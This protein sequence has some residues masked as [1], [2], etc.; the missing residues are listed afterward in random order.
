MNASRI[1]DF[2]NKSRE[3][4]S[5]WFSEMSLRGLLFHPEDA[6]SDIFV[7]ST[8]ERMFTPSECIR[9]ERIMAE[10]FD[11]FG[12]DVCAAAYPIF[13]RCAGMPLA[14]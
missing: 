1:P 8:N 12:D 11:L 7:V 13:M 6:P 2:V 14:A 4:M 9:L 5:I 3:G 10:M